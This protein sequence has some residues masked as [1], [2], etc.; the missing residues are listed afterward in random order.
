MAKMPTPK[1]VKELVPDFDKWP[2]TWMGLKEDLEY[3]KKLLP[4]MEQFLRHMIDKDLSR[5][6][7]KDY[8]HFL[9]LL[10]GR[11]IKEVSIYKEYKKEP[12]KKLIEVVEGCGC[13]PDG[14]EGMSKSELASFQKMCGKFEEFLIKTSKGVNH[15]EKTTAGRNLRDMQGHGNQKGNPKALAKMPAGQR[16]R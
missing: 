4:L 12:K 13:L 15:G 2:E 5:K 9:W 14:H 6:T 8:A 1:N 10:G 7:L 11:I 3:G 16:K